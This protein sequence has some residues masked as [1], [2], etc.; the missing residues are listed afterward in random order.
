MKSAN[1]VHFS[2][3]IRN[4]HTIHGHFVNYDVI[5][6]KVYMPVIMLTMLALE[7]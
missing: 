5:A 4:S 7:R 6:D 1:K 3:Y 2:D